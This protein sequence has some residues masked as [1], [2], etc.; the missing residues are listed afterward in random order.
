M[1]DFDCAAFTRNAMT[2]Y[3]NDRRD[4]FF[5]L[6][7]LCVFFKYQTTNIIEMKMT[8]KT[9]NEM[10]KWVQSKQRLHYTCK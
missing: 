8:K 10:I 3:L 9:E 5:A 6:K 4:L 7:F 1:N 2:E